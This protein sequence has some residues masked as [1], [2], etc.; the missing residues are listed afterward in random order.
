MRYLLVPVLALA[1]LG[2]HAQL[3]SFEEWQV[4]SDE[5]IR[6][7]PRYG[8]RGPSEV[9]RVIDED[10]FVNITN[11][12]NRQR[13]IEEKIPF[14]SPRLKSQNPDLAA[15]IERVEPREDIVV[16]LP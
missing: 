4:K 13:A 1:T 8:D 14:D 6:L 5:D 11:N 16:D 12:R 2:T 3:L 7:Q 10:V 15:V 9:N